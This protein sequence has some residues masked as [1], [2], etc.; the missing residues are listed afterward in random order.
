MGNTVT[1]FK[2]SGTDLGL[3]LVDKAYLIDRYPELADSFKQAGLWTWGNGGFGKLG[4]N[5]TTSKSSPVQT[6]AAG[7]NWKSVACGY[8]HT[9]AIKTDGTLW[10][11][12]YNS[13]SGQ[14]GDNTNAN[15]SSPVQTISG[16]TNWKQV[17]CGI[18]HN[19]AIKTDGTLWTW[20]YNNNG[21]LGDNTS[22]W[23]TNKSS[24][25]QTI[26]A[27]TNW[28]QVSCGA[29]HTAA[30]KTDGTLWVWASGGN[31]QLG[32]NTTANKSSPVQTIAAGTNWKQVSC[33][34]LHTV[35][36][37]TDGTLWAWGDNTFGDLGDN[38][39][40]NIRSSPVQ[41]IA[42]GTNW[43]QVSCGADHTAA[44]KTDGTLWAWGI[45]W[46]GQLGDNTTT[47][48]SSPVQTIAG[49][50]NWKQV[51]SGNIGTAAIK[52]D[53]TLWT[54]G[55]NGQGE[56][57]NNT[58]TWQSSPVQ[59]IAGGTNWK[60]VSCGINHTVAIRDD[61]ADPLNWSTGL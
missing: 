43:K 36:I 27:G 46:A 12:G 15:K 60:Q 41:T 4:D 59:T 5:T 55:I 33:G 30:I 53:G 38:T 7:T 24:P 9:A 51:S 19:A 8:A 61:S 57:G 48:K 54:W 11:W 18:Y 40:G 26:S 34:N 32:D 22:G 45:N 29:Q 37:K 56:L 49:G 47:G 21:Q 44:I 25:V 23:G 50:A 3:E 39:S 35:A 52:A 2:N 10:T 58:T 6:I 42:A 20:G 14:L 1:N 16:G 28:K 13:Y 17:A 31:G